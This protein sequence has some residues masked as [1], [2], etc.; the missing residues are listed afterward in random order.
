MRCCAG[1]NARSLCDAVCAAERTNQV[2][3]GADSTGRS[4]GR[5]T[6]RGAGRGTIRGADRGTIRGA[7]RG[8][9]HRS[10]SGAIGL[11]T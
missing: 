8:K 4:A 2:G 1:D 9:R 3:V 7:G 10:G 11:I 6:I 5:S